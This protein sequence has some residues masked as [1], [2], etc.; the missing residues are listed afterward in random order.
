MKLSLI[1]DFDLKNIDETQHG[2][3]LSLRYAKLIKDIFEQLLPKMPYKFEYMTIRVDYGNT[4]I[5]I[6]NTPAKIIVPYNLTKIWRIDQSYE[7]IIDAGKPYSFLKSNDTDLFQTLLIERFQIYNSFGFSVYDGTFR[8]TY[9]LGCHANKAHSTVQSHQLAKIN[10]IVAMC[11]QQLKP[12]IL[13]QDIRLKNSCLK[14]QNSYLKYIFNN[15][16]V[17]NINVPKLSDGELTCL[18]L[19]SRGLT[20]T[21]ISKTTGYKTYTINSYTKSARSS[22]NAQTTNEAVRIARQQNLII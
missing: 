5:F 4:S 8:F 17:D 11:I 6:S 21:E 2:N 3:I 20:V 16:E 18:H 1:N 12:L 19:Y 7:Q 9:I 15:C 14:H 10:S 22:L 13:D